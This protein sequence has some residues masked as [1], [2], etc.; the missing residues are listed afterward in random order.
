MATTFNNWESLASIRA[1]LNANAG[2]INWKANLSGGNT[3]SGTQNVDAWEVYIK[4]ARIPTLRLKTTQPWSREWRISS[5]YNDGDSIS[6][7]DVTASNTQRLI[8]GNDLIINWQNWTSAWTSYTPAV[9]GTGGGSG[10][11]WISFAK[12]KPIWKTCFVKFAI[13]VQNKNTLSWDVIVSLPF[14]VI[15]DWYSPL[16]GFCVANWWNPRTW[17]KGDAEHEGSWANCKFK[18]W[19]NTAWLQWSAVSDTD[20]FVVNGQYEIA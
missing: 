20:W 1:K 17:A 16:N 19:F 4:Q 15:W 9:T 3:F 6:I 18:S 2:E 13:Q 5:A 11:M 12:Y 8:L 7:V 14:S 10:T